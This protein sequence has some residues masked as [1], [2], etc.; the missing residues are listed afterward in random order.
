MLIPF[1]AGVPCVGH[2]RGYPKIDLAIMLFS[3]P[4]LRPMTQLGKSAMPADFPCQSK[5]GWDM[6]SALW[7]LG[8]VVSPLWVTVSLKL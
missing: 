5:L 4:A 8:A 1:Q 6:C 3:L 2:E 7:S